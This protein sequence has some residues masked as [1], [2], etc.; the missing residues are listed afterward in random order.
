[1]NKPKKSKNDRLEIILSIIKKLQNFPTQGELTC[2]NLYNFEYTAIKELKHIFDQYLYQEEQ[3]S[4]GL[5][6]KINFPEINRT[7]YYNF[8]VSKKAQPLFLL[9]QK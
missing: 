2:V 4:V 6:G 5:S 3:I 7:I 9:K 8:P 1:M